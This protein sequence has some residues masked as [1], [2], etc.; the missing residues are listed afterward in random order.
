MRPDANM[1]GSSRRAASL[2]PHAMENPCGGIV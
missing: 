2:A 1:G